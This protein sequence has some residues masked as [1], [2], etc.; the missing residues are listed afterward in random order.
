MHP[1]DCLSMLIKCQEVVPVDMRDRAKYYNISRG[2][3]VL[4]VC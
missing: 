2:H 3:Y 1:T 4:K